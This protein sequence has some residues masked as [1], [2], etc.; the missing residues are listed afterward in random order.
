[1]ARFRKAEMRM[2]A[3]ARF[4]SLTPPRPNARDL[5]IALLIGECTTQIPGIVVATPA[6]LADS[7]GWG[8]PDMR[9]EYEKSLAEVLMKMPVQADCEAGLFWLPN[10]G[11]Y[12][13]PQN[14]N[15]VIGWRE[16]WALIPECNLKHV[17]AIALLKYGELWGRSYYDALGIILG[18]MNDTSRDQEQE[19]GAG[20]GAGAGITTI[21]EAE[22][23]GQLFLPTIPKN[24]AG[25]AIGMPF[26]VGDALRAMA[27][28]SHGRFLPTNPGR[29]A[30][31]IQ[32]LILTQPDI[33]A[34]RL[35]GEWL[36]AGGEQ[37]KGLLDSRNLTDSNFFAWVERS[38]QWQR[39]GRPPVKEG[40][41][42]RRD[43]RMPVRND[44]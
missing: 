22:R 28:S 18:L 1:V 43:T 6:R 17:A 14:P 19:A 20:A 11:R 39:E 32:Q 41:P 40:S 23:A 7:L 36:A 21:A 37:W 16:T 15:V 30:V 42:I 5:W 26:S 38:Q 31:H 2:W 34:W 13:K 27:E 33:A 25:K 10:G 24:G 12:N 4:R 8:S 44:R 35:I 3:D 29:A 9:D